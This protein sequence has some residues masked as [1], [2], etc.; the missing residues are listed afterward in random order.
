MARLVLLLPTATYRA[1]DFVEAARRLG[2]EV[3]VVSNREQA[4]AE[5][6]GDRA[7]RVD[8]S[9]PMEAAGEIVALAE[10]SGVDGVVAVDDQGALVAAEAARRL[11]FPHNP[12][13]AMAATRDKAVMRAAFD[14]AGVRQPRWVAVGLG[15]DVGAA[16]EAMGPPCVMKPV[17]LSASRGVIRVDAAGDAA[18]VET[19]I[20][21]ILAEADEDP[22][23]TLLVEEFVAGAEVAVEG[24]LRDGRLEVLAVFDKPDPLDGPFFEETIYVTPSCQPRAVLGRLSE[25]VAAACSA[26]GLREGPVHA[27]ARIPADGQP[28]MLEIAARSIGGLCSRA[29]RFG[30][31]I[32]LEEVIVGHALG[33]DVVRPRSLAASGVMMLPIPAAGRLESVGGRDEALAVEGIEGLEITVPLG[34]RVQPLPEGDR[35]LGFLFARAATPARVESALRQSSALLRVQIIP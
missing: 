18:G 27:E 9:D 30:A 24:L 19:R 35:Y 10:R 4:M 8:L 26:L 23:G 32:S 28:V 11:N 6:M 16:V 12:L 29:L 15:D 34:R 31:G 33:I 17:P 25:L 3:V 14:R 22:A 21:S 20:R 7:L 2:A 5:S 13:E 1:P